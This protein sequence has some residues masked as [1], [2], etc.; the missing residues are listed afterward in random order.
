[1]KILSLRF[2]R[3]CNS[4][5]EWAIPQRYSAQR[6]KRLE[7]LRGPVLDLGCGTGLLSEGLEDVVGVDIAI[8]MAKVY[9]ERFGRV[10]IGDAHALPFKDRS[11]D[12]VISNFALHWTDLKRSIPEALRVCRR[13]F[14]CALPV[15]GSLPELLFPFPEVKSILSLLEGRANIRSFFLEEVKIPFSGWDLVKFFHYT[16]S[17]FNPLFKGGIISRKRIESMIYEIDRPAFRVLFFSCEVR[18]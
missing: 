4:Y 12:F 18:E 16:G 13:L 2:S 10:V 8:G 7:N 5:E 1:M 15:E 11:F 17:S 3:A 9:R 6:L 14:L